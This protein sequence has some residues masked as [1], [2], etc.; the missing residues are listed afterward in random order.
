MAALEKKGCHAQFMQPSPRN[1]S[2]PDLAQGSS[3][4]TLCFGRYPGRRRTFHKGN[5]YSCGT[6]EYWQDTLCS[7]DTKINIL[8]EMGI[9][10]VW[11]RPGPAAGTA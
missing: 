6:D 11:H 8:D 7:D 9:Q 5:L 4:K 3:A 1:R 10:R 2:A